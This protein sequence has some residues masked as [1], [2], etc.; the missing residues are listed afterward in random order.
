MT[1][2]HVYP[3]MQTA[4]DEIA[5]N[6]Q[7]MDIQ[8][9]RLNKPACLHHVLLQVSVAVATKN[10]VTHSKST[11]VGISAEVHRMHFPRG[12]AFANFGSHFCR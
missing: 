3:A 9:M 4:R 10:R 8:R 7:L 2:V 11:V 6:L 1:L 12:L 5:N